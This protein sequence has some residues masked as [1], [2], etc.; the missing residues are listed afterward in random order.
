MDDTALH[1]KVNVPFL[2]CE[3]VFMIFL[4]VGCHRSLEEPATIIQC[5][6]HCLCLHNCVKIPSDGDSVN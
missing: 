6:C 3:K 2:V 4:F 1:K 5:F